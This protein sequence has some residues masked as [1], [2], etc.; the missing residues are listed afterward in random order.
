MAQCLEK[1][2]EIR[3]N[4]SKALHSKS[5]AW[6]TRHLK[7]SVIVSERAECNAHL[8]RVRNHTQKYERLVKMCTGVLLEATLKMFIRMWPC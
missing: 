2:M 8:K 1:L 7:P 3:I 6:N 4:K 5:F